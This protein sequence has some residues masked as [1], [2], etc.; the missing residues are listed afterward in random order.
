MRKYAAKAAVATGGYGKITLK[1]MYD[2]AL[3]ISTSFK[4]RRKR[5]YQALTK[6]PA[7]DKGAAPESVRI[8]P[9]GDKV[10]GLEDKFILTAL[11]DPVDSVTRITWSSSDPEVAAVDGG[12]I[13]PMK[14]GTTV[15]TAETSAGQA[16]SIILTVLAVSPTA[17]PTP[18]P[19][20]P[21]TPGPTA[22]PEPAAQ[23][24]TETRQ[25]SLA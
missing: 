9:A 2:A 1:S 7:K 18:E 17:S 21:P 22:S 4:T 15:I 6:S 23:V 24:M 25:Q 13:T 12:I 8:S 14:L 5:V 16:D 3:E 19:T 10:V 20:A 11:L